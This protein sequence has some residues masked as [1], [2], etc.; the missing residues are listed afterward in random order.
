[1]NDGGWYYCVANWC[2]DRGID[3]G[4]IAEVLE[5]QR[6]FAT[7]RRQYRQGATKRVLHQLLDRAMLEIKH[8]D[9]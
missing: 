1:M 4:E 5:R 2:E 8:G 6:S 9:G 7:A 3:L